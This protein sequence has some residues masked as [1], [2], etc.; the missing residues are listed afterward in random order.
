MCSLDVA[1]VVAAVSQPFATVRVRTIWPCLWYVSLLRFA[2]Q[3]W[4]FVTFKR[5][6]CNVSKV[7]FCVAGAILF[8]TFFRRCVAFFSWQAHHFLDVVHRH[9]SWQAQWLWRRPSSDRSWARY[10]GATLSWTG[11]QLIPLCS[12][13]TES[14]AQSKP[15]C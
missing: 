14:Q 12:P 1:F 2:W 10:P 6:S 5:V 13:E 7:V 11:G 3:A 9:F 8:A 4:H 15:G